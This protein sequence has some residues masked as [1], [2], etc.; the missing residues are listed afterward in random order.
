M[1]FPYRE[2]LTANYHQ[3]CFKLEIDF[4]HLTGF[5]SGNAEKIFQSPDTYLP[6]FE[7]ACKEVIAAT[8]VPKP[9]K[10]DMP[11]FQ[12]QIK[13]FKRAVTRIRDLGSDQINRLVCVPGIIINAGKTAP[14]ATKIKIVCTNCKSTKVLSGAKG[15][16]SIPIPRTCG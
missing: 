16:G 11:D 14:V 7:L 6:L 1:R 10:A 13:N 5:D 3:K 12:V 2:K 9:K 15:F 4:S 8:S